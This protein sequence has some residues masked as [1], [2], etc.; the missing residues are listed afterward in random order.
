MIVFNAKATVAINID[1]AYDIM[2]INN[3]IDQIQYSKYKGT[4][5]NIGQAL[6]AALQSIFQEIGRYEAPRVVVL[7]TDEK[8]DD[9]TMK[10]TALLKEKQS[11]I[12][13]VGVGLKVSTDELQGIATSPENFFTSGSSKDLTL[14]L[15]KTIRKKMCSGKCSL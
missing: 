9:D 2:T 1:L 13:T 8:S 7:I 11:F 15:A 3:A 4:G 5:N 6:L 12:Y 14:S 10:A